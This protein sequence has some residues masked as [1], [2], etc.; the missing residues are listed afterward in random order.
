M[1]KNTVLYILSAVE[2]SWQLQVEFGEQ[3][4]MF[5]CNDVKF[6]VLLLEKELSCLLAEQRMNWAIYLEDCFVSWL[7]SVN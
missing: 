5:F 1:K 4:H 7:I 3:V 2:Q 6:A